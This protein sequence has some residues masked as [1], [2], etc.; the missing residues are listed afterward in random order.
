[1]KT[2][3]KTG[4]P[5]LDRLLDMDDPAT[6]KD[7]KTLFSG[8]ILVNEGS[9]T[10]VTAPAVP[11]VTVPPVTLISGEAGTGKTTLLLQMASSQRTDWNVFLYSLEQSEPEL[12]LACK[13]FGFITGGFE[14]L[15]QRPLSEAAPN[16]VKLCH[17]SPVPLGAASGAPVFE[18]RFS[19]LSYALGEFTRA[20]PNSPAKQPVVL[21]DSLNAFGS[22]DLQ[23]HD[24]CRLFALFRSHKIPAVAT[25]EAPHA[26][27]AAVDHVARDAR[28]LADIVI[29]LRKEPRQEY[30]LFDLEI[31]KNR[32]TRQALGR[33][34]YKIRTTDN[35]K[36]VDEPAGVTVYPSISSVLTMARQKSH[37]PKGK[38][39]V[40]AGVGGGGDLWEIIQAKE[41]P[42]GSCI[43]VTGPRGTHKRALALN[44]A[45][46]ALSLDGDTA[47]AVSAAP[48]SVVPASPAGPR[49]HLLVL[50]FGVYAGFNFKGTAWFEERRVWRSLKDVE[51]REEEDEKGKRRRLGLPT[52]HPAN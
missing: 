43:A 14:D 21:L 32:R 30:V 18:E 26:G 13:H 3:L 48:A 22:G 45:T 1:M 39:T 20:R 49:T 31:S 41:I 17:L 9:D 36:G 5:N 44:L 50:S 38:Y 27:S 40:T 7:G 24:L 47:V 37:E 23:R 11:P 15:A 29:D 33:H 19:Q 4:V 6:D 16:L 10:G 52:I 2:Y 46:G 8:G 35:A 42:H 25:C 51:K 12:S 34:L 28:F